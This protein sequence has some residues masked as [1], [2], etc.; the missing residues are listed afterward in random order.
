MKKTSLI[1]QVT[2][3]VVI[4]ILFVACKKETSSSLSPA[5]EQ[6][7]ATVS[8]E[9]ETENEVVFNDVFDNVMGVNTEV[10][11]GGTGIFG[12][13]ANG[14]SIDARS[15]NIDS[16]PACT[17][18]T[19]TRLSPPNLFPVKIVID[20]GSGCKGNDGRT[21]YGKIIITYTGR[22]LVPGSSAT[23]SFDGFKLDSLSVE[24]T[25]KI[26]NTTNTT[27]GSNQRQFTVDVTDAKITPPSG[28]YSRWN[29]HRVTTQVEGNGSLIPQDDV[30][31]VTGSA[32]GQVKRGN[33]I[34]GW[35]SE[36]TTPLIKKFSCRWISQG[37]I[38]IRR[39]TLAST[40]QWTAV[41]DYGQGSCDFYATLTINGTVYQ[42]QLPR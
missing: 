42:I 31:T 14:S 5:E 9:S 36:I 8:T 18:V 16:L 37:V 24:G 33:I 6:Q 23:T 22:L 38:K 19:I 30:F 21:R 39:E 25:H 15:S 34:Y 3:V 2:A 26:T 28:N 27:A 40:S 32:K 10:G 41:L 29:S 7:A 11:V 13:V 17:R 35:T 1:A 12:R 20:F 4:S